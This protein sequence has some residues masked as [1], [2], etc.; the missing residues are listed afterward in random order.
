MFDY[1]ENDS[2]ESAKPSTQLPLRILLVEDDEDYAFSLT[3]ALEATYRLDHSKTEA[4]ALRLLYIENYDV[5]LLDLNLSTG[6]LSGFQFLD[7]LSRLERF[8]NLIIIGISGMSLDD[9]HSNPSFKKLNAFLIKPVTRDNLIATI[10]SC[11]AAPGTKINEEGTTTN[12]TTAAEE[13]E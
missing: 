3:H 2:M 5:L 9:I 1:L 6:Y 4:E 11:L 12:E 8:K 13:I 7:Y 10:H